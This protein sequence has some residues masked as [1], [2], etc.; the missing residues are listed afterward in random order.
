MSGDTFIQMALLLCPF[1]RGDYLILVYIRTQGTD[2]PPIL[3]LAVSAAEQ[4]FAGAGWVTRKTIRF[5]GGRGF[6]G[7]GM[8]YFK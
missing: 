8:R 3:G 1:G 2:N 7:K 6:L 5:L 4:I